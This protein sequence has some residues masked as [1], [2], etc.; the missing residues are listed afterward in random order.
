MR[1]RSPILVDNLRTLLVSHPDRSMVKF[2]LEGLQFGFSLGF[3]G[4]VN[5]GIQRNLKSSIDS[6]AEVTKA[7][8]K[9]V[10]KGHTAGPFVSPPIPNL[11]CSPLGAVPKSDGSYRLIL[12][13]S[14]PHDGLSVNDGICKEEFLVTYSNFDQ[15]VDMVRDLGPNTFMAKIDI[16]HAYRNCPVRPQDFYLLGMW[17]EKQFFVDTRLPFGLRSAPFIFNTLADALCWIIINVCFIKFVLHYLDDFFIAATSKKEC[18]S[19][20]NTILKL[21]EYLGV[22]VATNKLVGPSKNIVYLGIEI[23][24]D[25]NLIR[26][27]DDKLE[28]LKKELDDWKGR[29]ICKK[30][31]LLSL[32]GKLSFASKVIKPGR[33]FVRRLINLSM[34]GKKLN[35]QIN[36]NSAAKADIKW[37]GNF[38]STWNGIA[39]IQSPLRS[40]DSLNLFT[41]ASSLKGYGAVFGNHWTYGSWPPNV[42]DKDINYKELLAILIA[43][44]TWKDEF[45]NQQIIVFTDSKSICDIWS[46]GNTVNNN[47]MYLIR[48]L[49]LFA[50]KNNIN[51]IFKHVPGHFNTLADCL[52]RFQVGKFKLLHGHADSQ[53]S[54]VP[55]DVW[56]T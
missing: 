1:A 3:K 7:I 42:K 21:F 56:T 41:D 6:P 50:A 36:L 13:L 22:P 2:L 47:I 10:S 31:E 39:I 25:L 30:R 34:T 54:A 12:D 19:H 40:S 37:W 46:K 28:V 26:L 16:K 15:A 24:T 33:I 53:L 20:K 51:I 52:S 27:P 11:H 49:F 55:K 29:K 8:L 32:I 5:P 38:I 14:S 17:W 23:N 43:I 48:K 9:E 44:F 35:H 45:I 18:E 4:Y